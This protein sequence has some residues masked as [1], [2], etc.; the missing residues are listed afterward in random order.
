MLIEETEGTRV[1]G[2]E[3]CKRDSLEAAQ[4]PYAAE[5]SKYFF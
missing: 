5:C 4:T 2:S 3:P 1:A